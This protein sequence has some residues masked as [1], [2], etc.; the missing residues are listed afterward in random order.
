MELKLPYES[1]IVELRRE[2]LGLQ[3]TAI[4]CFSC[5]CIEHLLPTTTLCSVT[6]GK[7]ITDLL[8]NGW[9]QIANSSATPFDSSSDTTLDA[10][11][12]EVLENSECFP[13]LRIIAE[14]SVYAAKFLVKYTLTGNIDLAIWTGYYARNAVKHLAWHWHKETGHK[15]SNEEL[16][17]SAIVKAEVKT[18]YYVIELLKNTTLNK[19]VVSNLRLE[20]QIRGDSFCSQIRNYLDKVE[21]NYGQ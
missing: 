7:L 8:K 18:Q 6:I 15:F 12:S 21:V 3:P 13:L 2:M 9:E 11:L 19:E 4:M 1:Y 14:D 10:A 20:A 17:A 5:V 16:L